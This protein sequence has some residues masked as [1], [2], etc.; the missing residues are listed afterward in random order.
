MEIR[1]SVTQY[2]HDRIEALRLAHDQYQY[3]SKIGAT[4]AS[5]IEGGKFIVD[6]NKNDGSDPKQETQEEVHLSKRIKTNPEEVVSSTKVEETSSTSI[7]QPK[8]EDQVKESSK[9]K[10]KAKKKSKKGEDSD[11]DDD[12]EEEYSESLQNTRLLQKAR[13]AEGGYKNVGVVRGNAMK[14]LP[15]YFERGQLK[16]IFFLFPDPHF[17]VR[18]HKSRIIS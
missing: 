3:L 13:T 15:N 8:P 14:F 4:S 2:V 11:E 1:S 17:K 18:K 10:G 5:R 7:Q 12:E 16:K 6:M 9:K